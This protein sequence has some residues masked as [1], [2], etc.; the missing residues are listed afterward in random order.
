M[1]GE[2]EGEAHLVLW[3]CIC[4]NVAKEPNSYRWEPLLTCVTCIIC[5]LTL[6][7]HRAVDFQLFTIYSKGQIS[8]SLLKINLVHFPKCS[9]REIPLG[10]EHSSPIVLQHSVNFKFAFFLL[11]IFFFLLLLVIDLVKKIVSAPQVYTKFESL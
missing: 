3:T 6:F 2:S 1:H 5:N 10:L 9:F 7:L 8:F 11:E 4:S